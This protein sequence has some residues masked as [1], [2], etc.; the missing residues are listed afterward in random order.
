METIQ[1][2]S[3]RL[4]NCDETGITTVHHKYTKILGLKGKLQISSLQSAE[5]RSLVTVVTCMS[6]TGQFIP[7]LLV[8]PRKNMK[9]E[10]MNGT[11]PGSI[12]ACRSSEWIQSEMFSQWFLHFIK[13][14]EP[15]K[16]DPV[17]LVLDG[18]YSHTRY[19]EVIK[20]S[21]RESCWHHLPPTSQQPQNATLG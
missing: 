18:Q 2:N 15:T 1:H 20:F 3:A 7:L 10:L 11:S 6:P 17:I 19:L 13:H 14:T 8:F 4:Y 21:S 16:E 5:R 9:Q 12:H